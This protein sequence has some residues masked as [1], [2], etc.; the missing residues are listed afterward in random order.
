MIVQ[1]LIVKNRAANDLS[2]KFSQL[3]RRPLQVTSAFYWLKG[4]TNAFTFKPQC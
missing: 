1:G 4:P 3:R 2:A